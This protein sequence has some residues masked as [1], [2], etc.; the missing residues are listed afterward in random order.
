MRR[1]GVSS[2]CAPPTSFPLVGD[3]TLLPKCSGPVAATTCVVTACFF[4]TDPGH[5]PSD[6]VRNVETM[7]AARG[8]GRTVLGNKHAS[9][10]GAKFAATSY[11]AAML[12]LYGDAFWISPYVFSSF[13]ALREKGLTFDMRPIALHEH[14]QRA[15]E[16]QQR[17]VTGRVPALDHDGFSLAE[18]SAIAEY[19]EDV[20]PVPAHARLLPSAPKD[21]ARA[22]QIMAWLR[23]D[24]T[25]ALR[26]ERSTHTMFYARTTNALGEAGGRAAAKVIAVAERALPS[27]ATQLFDAWSIADA[28]LAFML[29]RLIQNGDPVP[30]HVRAFADAQWNRPS[31]REFVD[32]KRIPFVPY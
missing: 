26:D 17:T 2:T 22:R 29:H 27:G 4:G 28:E 7:A 11:D 18:S 23:S 25:F 16:Y 12:T 6:T 32:Q 14:A 5:A 24:D 1:Y 13:V 15:P 9:A 31:S 19:L 10:H 21:R 20:F 3:P 30:A 8:A